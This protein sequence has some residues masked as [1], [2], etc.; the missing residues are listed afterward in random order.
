[1][2]LILLSFPITIEVEGGPKKLKRENVIEDRIVQTRM[3]GNK[4]NRSNRDL[5]N[6]NEGR[7]CVEGIPEHLA[8]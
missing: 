8:F 2:L 7:P 1:L 6:K 3:T 4:Q 5:D